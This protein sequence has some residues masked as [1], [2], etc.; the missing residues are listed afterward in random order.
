MILFHCGQF[1]LSSSVFR[2]IIKAFIKSR[3]LNILFCESN[4]IFE[5]SGSRASKLYITCSYFKSLKCFRIPISE[6]FRSHFA[7]IA[8]KVAKLKYFS[9]IQNRILT[10][11]KF[12]GGGGGGGTPLLVF[13]KSVYIVWVSVIALQKPK[14]R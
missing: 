12:E 10:S 1:I 5:I 13:C 2:E 14:V 4:Y 7:K 11:D 9:N 8:H 6:S 3:N